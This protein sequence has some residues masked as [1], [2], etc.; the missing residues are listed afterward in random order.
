VVRLRASFFG[1]S[2]ALE[3]FRIAP[4][5]A[6][7]QDEGSLFLVL[8]GFPQT[9]AIGQASE[10]D[11]AGAVVA[12]AGLATIAVGL[13]TETGTAQ[14]ITAAPG[15]VAVE[16][17]QASETD[18]AQ[19]AAASVTVT[20]GTASETDT[21]LPVGVVAAVTVAIGLA[22]ETDT[23]GAVAVLTPYSGAPTPE[24][25]AAVRA[26]VRIVDAYVVWARLDVALE[27]RTVDVPLELRTLEV[28]AHPRTVAA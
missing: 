19:P 24:R 6:W 28:A 17:G 3:Q 9:V 27:V 18:T 7:R 20:V 14:A 22:S 11:T 16:L 5:G 4:H 8:E 2:G 25:T 13:A 23:V 10:T 1:N 15:A 26:D 12:V 21:A